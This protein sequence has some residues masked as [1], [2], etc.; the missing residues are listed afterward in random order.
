MSA[1]STPGKNS[2]IGA[3]GPRTPCTRPAGCCAP[4]HA[5]SRHVSNTRYLTCFP[6]MSASPSRSP[7]AS[8]RTSLM[9]PAVQHAR[10]QDP[11]ASWNQHTDLY[12]CTEGPERAHYAG[13]GTQMQSRRYPAYFDHPHA[14]PTALPKPSTAA[15]ITYAAAPSE[16]R[17]LTHY[18]TRALLET[19]GFKPQLHPQL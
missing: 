4:D 3:G 9:L 14:P 18:I 17:N 15:L 12:A 10:R 8:T 2:T 16:L 19:G 11:Y 13:Q 1:V 6:A 5:C 7:G